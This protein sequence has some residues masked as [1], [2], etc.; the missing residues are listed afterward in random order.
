[1]AVEKK[2]IKKDMSSNIILGY[3]KD[4]NKFL[5]SVPKMVT[6]FFNR[7]FKVETDIPQ[8]A[9]DMICEWAAWRVNIM[10]ERKRQEYIKTLHEQ[11][12]WVDTILTPV[13]VVKKIYEDPI[14]ALGAAVNAIK[15]I[16]N[17]FIGPFVYLIQFLQE[18]ITELGRLA[19]NLSNLLTSLP[20]S[21]PSKNLN[22]DKFQ[23]KIG[24]MGISTILDDPER[25]PSPEEMFPEPIVPFS[26]AYFKA[27]GSEAKTIF[28]EEKPFYKLKD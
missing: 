4:F 9:V 8:K 7:I 28:R 25:L 23:L 24:T 17:I 22:F 27:L 19:K 15:Q 5:E 3:L 12:S 10:V 26:P 21:P 11:N 18:L 2:E 1:M 6:T 13:R 16:A 20:P 14:G